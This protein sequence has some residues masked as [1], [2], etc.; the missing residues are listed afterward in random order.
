VFDLGPWGR[1]LP[2]PRP[3]FYL[4]AFAFAF[5]A[6][7]RPTPGDGVSHFGCLHFGQ[8]NGLRFIRL[9]QPCP[10][11]RQSQTIFGSIGMFAIVTYSL[12]HKIY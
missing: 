9:I 10:H 2:F 8:L 12:Y 11:R 1:S 5:A 4:P 3:G 6:L 7:G